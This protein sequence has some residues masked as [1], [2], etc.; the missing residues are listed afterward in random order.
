[1]LSSYKYLF[2]FVAILI[3]ISTTCF[4]LDVPKLTRRVTDLAGALT[5]QQADDIELRLKK[6]EDTTST[7]FAVLIIPSIE[8]EDIK[9]FCI[10][11]AEENKIGRKEKNNG[12]L[13]LAAI[14]DKKM[15]FEVGYG[16]EPT[17]TDAYTTFIRENIIKP[18]FRTGDYYNGILAGMDAA[19]KA[20]QGEF[21][22][23]KKKDSGKGGWIVA[24][25]IA[26]FL[27]IFFSSFFRRRP[28]KGLW[29]SGGSGWHSGFGG[30]SSGGSS[31]G[32]W[33]GGGSSFDS[34]GW[35]GGGGSF[36]GGGSDGSW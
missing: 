11:V 17:L 36:G 19:M 27:I 31:G 35:S 7:Q 29:I 18:Y 2:F 24:I 4:A 34:G 28:G 23:E 1:M 25:I 6:F 9:D 15:R 32:G 20:T 22:A 14:N 30:W 10:R 26:I 12:M 8:D 21:Q 13:F 16:L 33:S 3:G 5:P